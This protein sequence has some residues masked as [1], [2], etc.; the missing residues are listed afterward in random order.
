[1]S[2]AYTILRKSG[3]G[4]SLSET[5]VDLI[6]EGRVYSA[7]ELFQVKYPSKVDRLIL[8]NK[9]RSIYSTVKHRDETSILVEKCLDYLT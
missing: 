5:L 4:H 6:R 3:M 9:A 7:W 1:M 2:I 8:I